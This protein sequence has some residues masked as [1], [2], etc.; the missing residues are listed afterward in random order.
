MPLNE[1]GQAIR[2]PGNNPSLRA[3]LDGPIAWMGAVMILLLSGCSLRDKPKQAAAPPTPKPVATVPTPP[4]R[5]VAVV[6]EP[7]SIP[8]TQIKLPAAQPIQNEALVQ[9]PPEAPTPSVTPAPAP[10]PARPTVP[11]QA[12]QP[13]PEP[14]PQ[15]VTPTPLPRPRIRPVQSAAERRQFES[16]L[17]ARQHQIQDLLAKVRSRSLSEQEKA[18]VERV[19]SFLD[20]TDIALKRDELLEADALS[21]RALVLS[22]DLASEK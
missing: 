22:L 6:N 19:Q 12:Q 8:Q 2:Q 7:Y 13:K 3:G 14:P 21:N 5:V 9:A 20:Q 11:A 18:T 17:A 16:T 1:V 4:P 15:V 10:R